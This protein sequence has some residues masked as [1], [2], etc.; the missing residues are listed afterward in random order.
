[1]HSIYDEIVAMALIAAHR[2]LDEMTEREKLCLALANGCDYEFTGT[3]IKLKNPVS[4][5]EIDGKITIY[6]RKF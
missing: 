2:R 3:G 1:M 6:E 4:F 5:V